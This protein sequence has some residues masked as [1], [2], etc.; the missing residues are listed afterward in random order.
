MIR[1]MRMMILFTPYISVFSKLDY[2][3]FVGEFFTFFTYFSTGVIVVF[4]DQ[5]G[6]V[7]RRD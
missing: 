2:W 7:G 6:G 3:E 1:P 4:G 5:T